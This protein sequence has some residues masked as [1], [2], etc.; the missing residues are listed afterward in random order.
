MFDL[1]PKLNGEARRALFAAVATA[2]ARGTAEITPAGLAAALLRTHSAASLC[3]TLNVNSTELLREL[4]KVSA[5]SQEPVARVAEGL[6]ERPAIEGESEEWQVD[7]F[8][9]IP[10]STSGETAFELTS[11]ALAGVPTESV[12]PAR[13]LVSLLEHDDSL[14]RLCDRHGLTGLRLGPHGK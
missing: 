12:D 3:N 10:L 7:S 11:R 4:D 1:I 8:V 2:S 5:S 9:A 13:I 14:R 6:T